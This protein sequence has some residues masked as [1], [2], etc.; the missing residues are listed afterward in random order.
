MIKLGD[1]GIARVLS[2]TRSKAK[3]E[4]SG[5]DDEMTPEQKGLR[6]MKKS[7]VIIFDFLFCFR[8]IFL[9]FFSRTILN[10]ALESS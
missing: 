8:Y 3:T 6:K 2:E 10:A 7:H 4:D 9:S 5:S 1:F